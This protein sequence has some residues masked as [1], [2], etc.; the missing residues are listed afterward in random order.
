MLKPTL[1][2]AALLLLA[3]CGQSNLVTSDL[4]DGLSLTVVLIHPGSFIMGTPPDEK[5]RD[6][7]E[8]QH[9]VTLTKAFYMG[10]TEVTQAQWKAVMAEEAP[11]SAHGSELPVDSVTWDQAVAFCE[12]LSAREGRK[13]RLPTEA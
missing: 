10:K 12:K 9:P 13:Y 11:S 3:G 8:L 1:V 6:A 7:D 2:L 5:G 4:G